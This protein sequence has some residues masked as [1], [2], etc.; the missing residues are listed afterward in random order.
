M[1]LSPREFNDMTPAEFFYAWM[2]WR[3][4]Q[5]DRARDE[6]ERTRWSTYFQMSVHVDPKHRGS[7][8]ELLRLPWDENK[9]AECQEISMEERRERAKEML[10]HISHE[11]KDSGPAD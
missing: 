11:Q 3:K 4:H 7:L 5:A 1:G 9:I 6:W 2:G 8:M 10:K